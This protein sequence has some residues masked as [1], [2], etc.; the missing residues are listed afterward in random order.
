MYVNNNKWLK[1]SK[2]KF[3]KKIKEFNKNVSK[4][5]YKSFKFFSR[6]DQIVVSRQYF[7]VPNVKHFRDLMTEKLFKN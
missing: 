2:K 7:K 1:F 3:I 5:N 4:G 6:N